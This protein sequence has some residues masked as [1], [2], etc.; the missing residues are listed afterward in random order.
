MFQTGVREGYRRVTRPPVRCA[1]TDYP[2]TGKDGPH[3]DTSGNHLNKLHGADRWS[4]AAQ[5]T[6]PDW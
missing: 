1:V 6:V 3:S 5:L 2:G 4:A